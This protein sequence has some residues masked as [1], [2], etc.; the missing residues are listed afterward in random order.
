MAHSA[1]MP[2]GSLV[3]GFYTKT[4]VQECGPQTTC[5]DYLAPDGSNMAGLA[6]CPDIPDYM[7]NTGASY[8]LYARVSGFNLTDC[9]DI[10]GLHTVESD[11]SYGAW[12]YL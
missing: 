9:V 6:L 3:G 5:L 1:Y 7:S 4:V 10:L 12:Q 11:V 8:A 2:T